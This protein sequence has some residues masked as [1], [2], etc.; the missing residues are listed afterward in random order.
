MKQA[1][2][3]MLGCITATALLASDHIDGPVTTKHGVSDLTDFYAFPSPSSPGK[4]TLVLNLYP[5]A[6]RESH[7]SS[8]VEY[9]FILREAEMVPDGANKLKVRINKAGEKTITCRFFTPH[10]H[11]S[12]TATCDA[13]NGMKRTVALD[14]IDTRP[15]SS[16]LLFFHGHRSDPF[17]F[18]ASWAG[19]LLD[20]GKISPPVKSNTISRMNVLSLV[21]ELD[22]NALFGKKAG[23]LALAARCV[24]VDETSGQRR[25]MDRIGRPEVTNIILHGHKGEPELRDAYNRESPFPPRGKIVAAYRERMIRNFAF[26]DMSD[27][28]ADWSDE[29][30][31]TYARLMMDDY[32]LINASKPSSS[33]QRRG[34]FSIETDVLNGIRSTAAG[35]RTL[36]DD[37]MDQLYTYMINRNHGSPIGDGV[38][39]PCRAVSDTFPY[40]AEPDTSLLGWMKAKVGRLATGSR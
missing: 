40:L 15:D 36:T 26:Y 35:G 7:F 38:N 25:Q 19:S 4:W 1:F 8:K 6:W 23:L 39:A 3:S 20:A 5:L 27:G 21:V 28:K 17:F 37:F 33:A 14:V 31:A 34:Y 32:L 12:H 22:L 13:G 30:R 29:Q 2:L 18:N 9:S 11:A 10:E 16:G 24:S